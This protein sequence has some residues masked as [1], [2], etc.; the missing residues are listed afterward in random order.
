[1]NDRQFVAVI[2]VVFTAST[3]DLMSRK[4]ALGQNETDVMEDSLSTY[5]LAAS[6]TKFAE[7]SFGYWLIEIHKRLAPHS[8]QSSHHWHSTFEIGKPYEVSAR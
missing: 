1:M 6:A 3:L 2:L 5:E 7:G 8:Q 4:L